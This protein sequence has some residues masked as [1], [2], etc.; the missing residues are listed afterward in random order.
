MKAW[1]I[2]T[3]A[4]LL[5]VILAGTGG[6]FHLTK[7]SVD[8]ATGCPTD[9]YD[10]ITVVLVDLTDAVNP[11]QAA[12]LRNALQKIRNEVPKFGR[13][14]I[15][16]VLPTTTVAIEPLF[17]GCSPGSG[18]DVDNRLYGNPDLADRLWNRQFADKINPTFKKLLD[19]QP[20][21]N[22]P[23][24]EAIQSV[25]VTAF[26][27][28]IAEL[29]TKRHMVLVSDMIHHTTD[30]SLYQGAPEFSR[31]KATPYYLRIKPTLR[32]A[33][34]DVF[35]IVRETRKNIQ[36]PPLYKFWVEHISS[37]EGYLRNWEP[38]Q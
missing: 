27:T 23:L 17:A 24:L 37:G 4:V 1:I 16:P 13:L 33:D 22:S 36:Q 19:L 9:R 11:V 38:L 28:P 5:L 6:Y 31:F 29:A 34:V 2:G 3:I 7:R 8:H 15:Y 35:L 18:R 26:G 12:A 10:S 25:A 21:E 32:D 14:E 30:L 20:Q